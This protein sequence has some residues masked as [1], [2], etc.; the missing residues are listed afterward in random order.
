MTHP[1]YID[2]E[3]LNIVSFPQKCLPVKQTLTHC[4]KAKWEPTNYI[5]NIWVLL[6]SHMDKLTGKSV[7]CLHQTILV[8]VLASLSDSSRKVFM[9]TVMTQRSA[10]QQSSFQTRNQ[11]ANVCP[12]HSLG[13]KL[14]VGTVW[15]HSPFSEHHACPISSTLQRMG[16]QK[17]E[18]LQ[19]LLIQLKYHFLK[20]QAAAAFWLE[21]SVGGACT[22]RNHYT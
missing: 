6:Q 14:H 2:R 10:D 17:L 7:H 19:L 9:L 12:L 3:Q 1:I 15:K 8:S 4:R 22:R 16:K 20:P 21:I 5:L 18:T 13:R 11:T